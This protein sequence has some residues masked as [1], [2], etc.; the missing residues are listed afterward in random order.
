MGMTD[1]AFK[2]LV[3][4]ALELIPA[5]FQPY[6]ENVEIVLEDWPSEELLESLDLPED[7]GLYGLY[8]GTPLPERSFD[9]ADFPDRITLFRGPLLEDFPEGDELRREVAFTVL[10]EIAHHFGIDEDRLEE[11]GL[12]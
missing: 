11:L 1:Q 9:H 12:D 6:L 10:H 4:E 5:E 3:A 7:E 8:T 2:K